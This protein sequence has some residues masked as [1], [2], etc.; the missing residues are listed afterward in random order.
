MKLGVMKRNNYKYSY[1]RRIRKKYRK[2]VQRNN[3][4]EIL[5]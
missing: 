4:L 5:N 2:L 1:F 3:Y